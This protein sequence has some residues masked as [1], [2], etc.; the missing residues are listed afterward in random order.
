M[1]R[2]I[3]YLPLGLAI[4][5]L[6]YDLRGMLGADPRLHATG[7]GLGRLA[8]LAAVLAVGTGFNLA[9]TAGLGSG[10][11][12][13]GHAGIALAATLALGVLSFLRYSAENRE[14]DPAEAGYP[15][16]WLALQLIAT[17][18]I[19]IAAVLGFRG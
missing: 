13:A 7:S 12:V 6:V 8:T 5:A 11:S 15:R 4:G 1:H 14:E 18:L 2:L 10:G 9:G 3:V 16:T 19:V 17:G